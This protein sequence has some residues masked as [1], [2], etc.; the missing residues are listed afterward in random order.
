MKDHAIIAANHRVV[1]TISAG[2]DLIVLGRV[3][4]RI[5]SEASVIIEATAIVEG[6]ITA[7]H[8]LV[9]GVVVGDLQGVEGVE[10]A[11]GAQVAGDIRT[12]RLTLRAGGRVAGTVTTGIEVPGYGSGLHRASAG[13][14]RAAPASTWSAPP[15]AA[16]ATLPG[17]APAA[18][19]TPPSSSTATAAVWPTD[20]AVEHA[21]RSEPVREG[22]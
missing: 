18:A 12:R 14:S 19:V 9:R 22:L 1:G 3:E 10:V 15:R 4:G 11:P 6:D 17:L 20:E 7:N 13:T 2:E 5:Q 21:V 8:V 16:A